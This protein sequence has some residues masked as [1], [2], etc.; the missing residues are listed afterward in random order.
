M[1]DCD[2]TG[3]VSTVNSGIME[4]KRQVVGD[5]LK[6]RDEERLAELEKK[7]EERSENLTAQESAKFFLETFSK[8]KN[9]L[10]Q[11]LS[12]CDSLEKDKLVDRFDNLSVM[13][14]KLQR[15]LTESTMFLS[16]YDVRQT[17]DA[18]SK[19]QALIQEKRDALL[20]KKKF[21]FKSKKKGT[22]QQKTEESKNSDIPSVDMVELADCK[23]TDKENETLIMDSSINMKDV[24]LANLKSC[25]VKLFGAPSAIHVN[26]LVNCTILSGPVS[27]SIFIR[28]CTNCVFAVP[29][30]QLRIHSTTET[31]FFI[32]VTSRAIIEDC[33]KVSFGPYNWTYPNIIDHYKVSGLDKNRNTWDDIDDFNWL[34]A[35]QRSPNW[36]L[37]PE[38]ERNIQWE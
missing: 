15:F 34:A 1:A 19:L 32:H 8:N 10:E 36:S 25:T 37:I 20:P 3:P 26:K 30:Q 11:E 14:Q 38:D 31:K 18:L 21:A 27:G 12:G 6:R 33:S 24:A 28:E 4:E 29:C 5:R 17:Q 7:K 2:A 9:D 16:S 35:D 13:H 23:F 22:Q